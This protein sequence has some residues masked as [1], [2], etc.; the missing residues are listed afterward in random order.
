M[1][2][3]AS[4]SAIMAYVGEF[5][6]IA[7]GAAILGISAPIAILGALI[8]HSGVVLTGSYARFERIT[9]VLTLALFSFVVLAVVE[10]PA[11]SAIVGGLNPLTAPDTSL[12]GAT[13]PS[14]LESRIS[15]HRAPR[16]AS[17]ASPR[18]QSRRSR[19]H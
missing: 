11:L 8:L 14:R 16:T 12:C 9:L 3:G 6:G 1:T 10:R 7:L 5:A 17:M 4:T 2:E 18:R 13:Y 19:R 15:P